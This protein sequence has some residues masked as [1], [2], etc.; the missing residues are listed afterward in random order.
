MIHELAVL[1]KKF[2]YEIE[3]ECSETDYWQ[4]LAFENHK[5]Y[6]PK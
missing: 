4:M 3:R 2:P 1:L 5:N 6:T